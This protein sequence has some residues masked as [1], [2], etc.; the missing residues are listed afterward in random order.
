MAVCSMAVDIVE[1]G[2]GFDFIYFTENL[3]VRCLSVGITSAISV[4][5][6]SSVLSASIK[7]NGTIALVFIQKIPIIQSITISAIRVN[8]AIQDFYERKY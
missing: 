6:I 5:I 4:S 2:L 7:K 8:P 3:M 1:R